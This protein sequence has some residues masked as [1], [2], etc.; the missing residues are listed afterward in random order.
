MTFC[1]GVRSAKISRAR[2]PAFS[3]RR[4]SSGSNLASLA[5]RSR[6]WRT[7]ST[8]S[9]TGVSK[10]RTDA[11]VEGSLTR[12]GHEG[13]PRVS[14]RVEFCKHDATTHHDAMGQMTQTTTGSLSR[15]GEKREGAWGYL[16]SLGLARLAVSWAAW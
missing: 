5:A 14:L 13:A 8:R 10:G 12:N 1:I 15:Q 9:T 2:R 16:V 4:L 3:S 7:R 11:A 6:S